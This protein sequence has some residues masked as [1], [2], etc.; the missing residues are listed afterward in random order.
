MTAPSSLMGLGMPP[1]LANALGYA[2]V[3]IAGVGTAQTGAAP[4]TTHLTIA[5]TASSQTAFLL[6]ANT[7][8]GG[9]FFFAN[10]SATAALVYG[11]PNDTIDGGSANA[12]VSVAQNKVRIFVRTSSTTW[13]SVL[14][15]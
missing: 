10:T 4:L 2:P 3:T 7:A 6:P 11:Q 15:A 1:A 13:I 8:G 12:S 5:T 9:P 14:T